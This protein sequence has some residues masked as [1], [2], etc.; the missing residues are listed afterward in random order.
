GLDVARNAMALV[1]MLRR[2]GTLRGPCPDDRECSWPKEQRGQGQARA[3]GW[4]VNHAAVRAMA[5]AR[6]TYGIQPKSRRIASVRNQQSPAATASA[7]YDTQGST[8]R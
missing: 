4:E 2:I 3:T 7:S 1:V 6:G 8:R 5:S